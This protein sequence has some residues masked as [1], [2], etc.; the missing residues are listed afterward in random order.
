MT[1]KLQNFFLVLASL[2]IALYIS[3]IIL[4]FFPQQKIP[5]ERAEKAKKQGINFDTRTKF[6]FV[7]DLRAEGQKAFP[8]IHLWLVT[9]ALKTD[10]DLYPLSGA[11]NKLTVFGN[12]SGQYITYVSDQYGF[13]NQDIDWEESPEIALIGDSFVQGAY[14]PVQKNIAGNLNAKGL[15]TLNLGIIGAGPLI[16][17]GIIKEY[18]IHLKPKKVLWFY[19][20]ANDLL[21]L[22]REKPFSILR[23]YLQPDFRQNLME[24][25]K[26]LDLFQ[27]DYLEKQLVLE[28]QHYMRTK[29]RQTREAENTK[30]QQESYQSFWSILSLQNL[31]SR[32]VTAID[33]LRIAD[34]LEQYDMP[35][36]RKTVSIAAD[37]VSS[38]G[39]KFYFIYLPSWERYGSTTPP[40]MLNYRSDILDSIADLQLPCID[41]HKRFAELEDPTNMFPFQLTGHYTIEGYKLV[42]DSIADFLEASIE[43]EEQHPYSCF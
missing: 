34:D 43:S 32:V 27:T 15:P 23:N 20:E 12:E 8:G 16:E 41:I 14:V 19:F 36:F 17:L 3:E 2:L 13:N 18:L 31:Q 30:A 1:S 11:A 25:Q 7:E 26:E 24:R 4:S 39:G 35:L 5:L 33:K 42:T 22:R 38:W 10:A 40:D 6:E 37:T 28:R 9:R 29:A 21:D